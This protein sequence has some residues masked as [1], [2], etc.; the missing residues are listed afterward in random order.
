[1]SRLNK[2]ESA[3]T[4][5][6]S[7][8]WK[9]VFSSIYL[10]Y[11]TFFFT[12]PNGSFKTSKYQYR[13]YTAIG[14]ITF[15]RCIYF[16]NEL[17]PIVIVNPSSTQCWLTYSN[18]SMK[19]IGGFVDTKRNDAEILPSLLKHRYCCESLLERLPI[20][21]IVSLSKNKSWNMHKCVKI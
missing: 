14:T 20:T 3:I 11:V 21:V 12:A 6:H 7:V 15:T 1:M 9:D 19:H 16:L 18:C 5:V 8:L 10:V 4:W 2:T 17:A 13:V